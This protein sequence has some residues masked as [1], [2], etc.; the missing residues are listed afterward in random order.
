M[1]LEGIQ[2]KRGPSVVVMKGGAKIDGAHNHRFASI[3]KEA[4]A[5]ESE[6]DVCACRRSFFLLEHRRHSKKKKASSPRIP[7]HSTD[8]YVWS[9]WKNIIQSLSNKSQ[10]RKILQR[11]VSP[12][13][14]RIYKT[15]YFL[16]WTD[17][18]L[19]IFK[20]GCFGSGNSGGSY[21][22]RMIAMRATWEAG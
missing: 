5:W 10:C 11:T 13:I 7:V 17:I 6:R 20:V 15:W 4:A 19:I 2:K 3:C 12:S 21:R 18:C 14:E 8:K 1:L 9:L 22:R 16:I